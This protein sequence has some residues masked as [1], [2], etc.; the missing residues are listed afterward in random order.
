M[1]R[2]DTPRTKLPYVYT[3]TLADCYKRRYATRADARTAIKLLKKQKGAT[4]YCYKCHNCNDYHLTKQKR[5][6]GIEIENDDNRRTI[7]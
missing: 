7:R 6:E 1:G 3:L 2:K 5:R 4:Q